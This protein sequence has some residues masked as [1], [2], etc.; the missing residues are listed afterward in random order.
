MIASHQFP[1]VTE[2]KK[3]KPKLHP[4]FAQPLA[5]KKFTRSECPECVSTT[6][7]YALHSVHHFNFIIDRRAPDMAI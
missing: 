2:T 6:K 4:H 1:V 5:A 7:T 3:Q